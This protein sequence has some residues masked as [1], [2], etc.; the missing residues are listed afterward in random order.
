ML[1]CYAPT[2]QPQKNPNEKQRDGIRFINLGKK[3]NV[4]RSIKFKIT[5][6]FFSRLFSL[7]LQTIAFIFP[8][9]VYMYY[10]Y[11]FIYYM[12]YFTVKLATVNLNHRS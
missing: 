8:A 9:Y 4:N 5:Y 6:I 1:Y 7:E 12:L 10:V 3:V 11:M 2:P